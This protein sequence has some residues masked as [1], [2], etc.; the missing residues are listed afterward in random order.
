MVVQ[1]EG[2]S[3]SFFRNGTG[4]NYFMAVKETDF[5]LEEGILTEI[6]GRSGSGKTTFASMLAGILLPSTGRVLFGEKDLYA[7]SDGERSAFRNRNIGIIPQGQTGLKSLTVLENVLLPASMYGSGEE[8][9]NR[10]MELLARMGIDDLCEVYANEL[11]G[12]EL[13]RMAIARALINGPRLVIADEP[14]GDLDDD[15]TR[16]VMEVL[17][18]CA[19]GG[20]AVLMITHEKDAAEYADSIWEMKGGV[21]RLHSRSARQSD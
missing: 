4:S 12:G 1:A 10:A 9:K 20:A 19:D 16:K 17:R 7:L 18:A 2:I 6:M 5:S 21:L 15:S 11:S 13:R 3:R 14:T 8:K